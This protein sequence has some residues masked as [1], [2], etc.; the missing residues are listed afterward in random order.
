MKGISRYHGNM[1][2]IS[3][4]LGASRSATIPE[5]VENAFA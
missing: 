2:S 3:G 1:A 4:R 5:D